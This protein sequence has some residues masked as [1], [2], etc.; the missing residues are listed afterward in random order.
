MHLIFRT[1]CR[2]KYF[3]YIRIGHKSIWNKLNGSSSYLT[4]I[5]EIRRLAD[6]GYV[7]FDC[8][9]DIERQ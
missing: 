3:Q 5:I 1:Y 6:F 8:E 7:V 2:G 9:G 4:Y